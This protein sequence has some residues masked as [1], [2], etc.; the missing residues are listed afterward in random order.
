MRIGIDFDGVIADTTIAKQWFCKD[1]FGVDIPTTLISGGGAKTL[2]TPE[3]YAELKSFDFGDGT[4]LAQVV[5]GA[6]TVMSRLVANGHTLI[7]VTGRDKRGA[8]Y[9][10]QFLNQH[11]IPYH[12][13][14]FTQEMHTVDE[15]AAMG[16]TKYTKHD[17]VSRLQFNVLI[18]DQYSNLEE[19]TGSGCQLI[20]FD[21]PWN[22]TTRITHSD[23]F[24]VKDW[25][26]AY[27]QIRMQ[28][29][30]AV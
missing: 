6:K 1:K 18:D 5:P 30:S 7:I 2:L 8:T 29:R 15:F 19:S 14:I 11:T 23:I 26:E 10:K 3:Q 13:L 22:H 12:H 24:R 20:L 21:Q 27:V 16:K 25:Q 28:I 9:A 17:I 4:L